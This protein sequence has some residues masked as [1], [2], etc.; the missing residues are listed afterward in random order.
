M[1]QDNT[2]AFCIIIIII[3]NSTTREHE[4]D[5]YRRYHGSRY[6]VA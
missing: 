5:E 6:T 3:I 4:A 2:K 1:A